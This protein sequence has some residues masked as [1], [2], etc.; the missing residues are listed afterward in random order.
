VSTEFRVAPGESLLV[1]R[2]VLGP[3]EAVHPSDLPGGRGQLL[4][5]TRDGKVTRTPSAV[6]ATAAPC[7]P[8]T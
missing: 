8:P 5:L 2:T 4:A 3:G 7:S 6:L 1:G